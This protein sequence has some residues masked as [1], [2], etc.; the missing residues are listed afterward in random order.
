MANKILF[1]DIDGVL[2]YD[3]FRYRFGPSTLCYANVLCLYQI[4]CQTNCQIVISST[5]RIGHSLDSFKKS[6]GLYLDSLPDGISLPSYIL[7]QILD[8]IVDLVPDGMVGRVD[9]IKTWLDANKT[10]SYIILDDDDYYSGDDSLRDKV[11]IVDG[12]VGLGI[13]DAT[14]AISVFNGQKS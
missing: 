2:N 6:F 1:L 8:S 14:Q 13:D 11:V 3:D 4:M 12:S 7:Q 5:W 9:D 10:D